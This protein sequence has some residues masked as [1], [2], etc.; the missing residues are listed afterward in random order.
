MNYVPKCIL[1]LFQNIFQSTLLSISD[2]LALHWKDFVDAK[3]ITVGCGID[4]ISKLIVF[5]R[6]GKSLDR[7]YYLNIRSLVE[8]NKKPIVPFVQIN[9]KSNQVEG[10]FDFELPGIKIMM[11]AGEQNFLWKGDLRELFGALQQKQS[12][13]QPPILAK[14]HTLKT[15]EC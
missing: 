12:T 1:R 2:H 9:A 7:P 4:R 3:H 10:G 11:N 13:F 8:A 5:T 14:S 15:L 6:D